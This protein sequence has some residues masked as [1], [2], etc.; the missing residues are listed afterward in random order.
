MEEKRIKKYKK[1]LKKKFGFKSFKPNQLEIIDCILKDKRDVCAIMPTGYGKSLCYQFPPVFKKKVS[2]VISPLISLMEDQKLQLEEMKIQVCCLNSVQQNSHNIINEII[3]GE[4][5]V[6]YMTP[7]YACKAEYLFTELAEDNILCLVAI[8]EAHCVSLWGQSFRESYTHL[9]NIKEWIG[10]TPI[11]ALTATAT[12]KIVDDIINL[13]GLNNPK[14]VISSFDRPNL[15]IE[16]NKKVDKTEKVLEPLL[17]DESTGEPYDES[18]IIYCLTR[19]ETEKTAEIVC[20]MGI[21]CK[22]Y[23]AGL[24]A[25]IRNDIHHKFMKNELKCISATIA[26]GMGINK[27]DIR[28]VIHMNASKD[29]ESYYQEIGRAGR[30]GKPSYCYMFYS[31]KDFKMHYHF[32]EN[33]ESYKFKRHRRQMIEKMEKYVKTKICRRKK[34]LNYFDEEYEK[35]CEN[36]NNCIKTNKLDDVLDYTIEGKQLLG[37]VRE[38]GG[39]FGLNTLILIIRGSKSKKIQ[40]KMYASKY[41][42]VGKSKSEK[43]WKKIGRSMIDD[44]YL[45]EVKVGD[46][47]YKVCTTK[48]GRT[49]YKS[50]EPLYVASHEQ[51]SML[52][53]NIV[54]YKQIYYNKNI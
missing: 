25:D 53:R 40:K 46:F 42:D 34:L 32:L 24:A 13:L 28:K 50:D 17:L 19:K 4:Y 5:R 26:F 1:K 16:V 23:H 9:K 54:K 47:G 51:S 6:V 10:N 8:D 20:D 18:I 49:W 22:A 35:K 27:R 30:D 37:L 29:I 14:K 43:L 12:D 41:Y 15:Y 21:K 52:P 31:H 45:K 11:I 36:C 39:S 2:I 48:M 3:D 33:I 7:E 38:L 44:G